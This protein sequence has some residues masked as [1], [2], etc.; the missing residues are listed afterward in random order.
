MLGS[1]ET[2]CKRANFGALVFTIS[3]VMLVVI[4]VINN[5]TFAYLAGITSLEYD[6]KVIRDTLFMTIPEKHKTILF[7]KATLYGHI[8]IVSG[9]E[10]YLICKFFP[11]TTAP[12]MWHKYILCGFFVF[13]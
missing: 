12:E 2:I 10:V 3:G 11:K 1:R 6:P 7:W 9:L 8:S 5:C 13:L 4:S